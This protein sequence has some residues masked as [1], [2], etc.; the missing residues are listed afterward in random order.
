MGMATWASMLVVVAL[1]VAGGGVQGLASPAAGV[2]SLGRLT[3]LVSANLLLVQVLLM[4]SLAALFTPAFTLGL[5]ALPLHLYAHGSSLLG[6]AQ[7]VAAAI[8]TALSITVLSWRSTALATAG[9]GAD[10]A[11]A[12]GV[13]AAFGVSAALAVGVVVLALFL[14]GRVPASPDA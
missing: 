9:A 4:A 10:Q 14:P 8:G 7:Q 3:G 5:G 6:T 13:R 12:G 2:T 1:W 11:F